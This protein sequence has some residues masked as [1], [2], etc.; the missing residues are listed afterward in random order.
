MRMKRNDQQQRIQP[1]SHVEGDVV[2]IDSD[3]ET[4]QGNVPLE[5]DAAGAGYA[6]NP[7]VPT[8]LVSSKGD[9]SPVLPPRSNDKVVL[10][11]R[12]FTCKNTIGSGSYSKVKVAIRIRSNSVTEKYAFKI[13]DRSKAPKDFQQKFLPR[14]LE[15]WPRLKHPN[16]IRMYTYFEYEPKIY[17][18]LEYA[19]GGDVLDY[20]QKS[21]ALS[22]SHAKT[23][24]KQILDA[25]C[26]LHQLGIAH[27]DLKLENV[28]IDDKFNIKICDFGFAKTDIVNPSSTF[29]GSKAY[30]A[31]EILAGHEYVPTKADVWAVG[32]ILYIFV[33][34]TMPFNED[35]KNRIILQA[36]RNLSFPWKNFS[37]ISEECKKLILLMFTYDFVERPDIQ[38]IVGDPWFQNLKPT[39]P[40]LSSRVKSRSSGAHDGGTQDAYSSLRS[41]ASVESAVPTSP[42]RPPKQSVAGFYSQK[43]RMKQEIPEPSYTRRHHQM[44][45]QR[46]YFRHV[47]EDSYLRGGEAERSSSRGIP[48][49][50]GGASH[51][52]QA[53]N[54]MRT[55]DGQEGVG[56]RGGWVS[57]NSANMSHVF[58]RSAHDVQPKSPPTQ[59]PR[60]K[61]IWLSGG[62]PG[63]SGQY[64]NQADRRSHQRPA[65]ARTYDGFTVSRFPGCHSPIA[66]SQLH[67]DKIESLHSEFDHPR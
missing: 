33:T 46:Q 2:V 4:T 15:I 56:S 53:S 28:L 5:D 57:P 60:P 49:H 39:A 26:Y 1:R 16:I 31:P 14:E 54:E 18:L 21:G 44:E 67:Y 65:P 22:Q 45:Q 32:V 40:K 66:A 12:G 38:I 50:Q 48:L 64:S 7:V 47:A 24:T 30:A 23:W 43:P 52:R 61:R 63:S 9:A 27:R 10:A 35:C 62:L 17:M 37:G 3:F 13:I 8:S 51:A 20:V 55:R 41:A 34:G 29:C 25:V 42:R 19:E 36:Q 6:S 11:K 58:G 59:P